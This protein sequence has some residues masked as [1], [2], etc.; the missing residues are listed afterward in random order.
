MENWNDG[1]MEFLGR[2]FSDSE[3]VIGLVGAVGTELDKVAKLPKIR[4]KTSFAVST[5]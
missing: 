5:V 3:L 1:D 4:K 2:K